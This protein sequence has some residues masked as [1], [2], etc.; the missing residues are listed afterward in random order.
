[1]RIALGRISHEANTFCPRP[2]DLFDFENLWL[3]RGPEILEGLEGTNIEESGAMQVLASQ[4]GC[5]VVPL[6]AAKA[7]SGGPVT[8]EAFHTLLDELVDRLKAALPVAGV[9]LILHGAMMSE[10]EPDATGEIL[11]AVRAVVGPYL[12]IVG[13]LDL[14]ANVTKLMVEKATALIGYHTTP[15]IDMHETGKTAARVLLDTVQGELSPTMAL[16]RLPMLIPSEKARHT[17]GPLAEVINMALAMEK[18][19]VILHAGI[20][21]VQPWLDVEDTGCAVVVV[22]DGDPA[23]AREHAQALALT[24]WERRWAFVPELVPPDEAIR[25]AL[26]REAGTVVFCD[27]ADSPSSGATG[28]STVILKAML[29]AAP[30]REVALLNV[31]DPG[32]VAQAIEAGVGAQVTVQVGGRLAPSFYEPVTYSGYVKTISDGAFRFKGPGMHG[33]TFHMG[34]TVVLIQDGIHLVVM[35]RPVT[36]WDPELYRSLGEEPTDARIVQVK[37]PAAFRAAYEGIADEI[38]IVQSP[39]I[40]SPDLASLPWRR[41]RRPIYPLDPDTPCPLKE[42]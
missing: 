40:S 19:G 16:V 36:Q 20:Y 4:P 27:S 37:S 1:M 21:P 2:T 13:T 33:L 24:F 3:R 17:D 28:D 38:I 39:G 12:P 6:L 35:E 30:M 14:H 32:A 31:V 23:A 10:D 25:R 42:A 41:L 29:R 8:A 9:L 34:R 7:V 5:D 18:E 11:R 26:G 22:T 15:H